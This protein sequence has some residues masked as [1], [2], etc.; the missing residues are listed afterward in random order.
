MIFLI[1]SFEKV[2][3]T[4]TTQQRNLQIVKL[5]QNILYLIAKTNK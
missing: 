1:G 4:G 2:H 3:D 5:D